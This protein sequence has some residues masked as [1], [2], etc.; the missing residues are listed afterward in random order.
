MHDICLVSMYIGVT[1]KCLSHFAGYTGVW[2]TH[3]NRCQFLASFGIC[4]NV[5]EGLNWFLLSISDYNK[6]C[7]FTIKVFWRL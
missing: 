6:K 3:E 4:L 1:V 2:Q 7:A 5:F